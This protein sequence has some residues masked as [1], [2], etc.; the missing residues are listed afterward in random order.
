MPAYVL[1]QGEVTNPER[2]EEYKLLAQKSIEAAGGRYLV[3]GGHAEL[4]EGTLPSRTVVLEF[5]DVETARAWYHGEAYAQ[6]RAL[7]E[8]AARPEHMFVIEGWG[9]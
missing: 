3:R 9:G 6:A 2:Y 5:A 4:F 1:F 7:R 8:G